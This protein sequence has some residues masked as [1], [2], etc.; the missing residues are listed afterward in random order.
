MTTTRTIEATPTANG[1]HVVRVGTPD[2]GVWAVNDNR[3]QVRHLAA[4]HGAVVLR[5]FGVDN[6]NDAAAVLASLGGE[7]MTEREAFAAR[8]TLAAGVY[9]SATWQ[10]SQPMCQHHELSY[11]LPAPGLVM[12]ACVTPATEGG[13]T[14]LADA[15]DVLEALPSDV[16]DR[17]ERLGW[18]LT[19]SYSEEIGASW[20]AAFG[21]DDPTAVERY[22]RRHG[23]E[24]SWQSDGTLR[25]RQR[26][27]AVVTHAS[28]GR[29]C[30][31]NQI[32]FLS[33]WT[34][35]PDVREFLVAEFGGDG[36]PFNTW[37]GDGS[38][39]EE[40][41]VTTINEV[42]E[43]MT[44]REPWQAGDVMVIDNVRTAHSRE[45]YVGRREVLVGF[46]EPTEVAR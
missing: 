12:L 17:F 21:T 27:R 14:G 39:V 18:L 11:A 28:S 42:Y 32:A 36:L 24:T 4:E 46:A 44:R 13:V 33:Q 2:P 37:Y 20:A 16:V 26:R 30:W 23:I 22:C 43:T 35:D 5:G 40:E 34:L 1:V 25:T 10:A 38:P 3:M 19:R 7:L 31:F 9:S 8:A 45:P 15:G 41:V 6:P 29:R